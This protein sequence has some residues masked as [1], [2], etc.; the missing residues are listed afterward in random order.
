MNVKN[1][2]VVREIA[3]T[4]YRAE[5]K[6]NVLSVF[7]I[8]MA[9]FFIA[10]MTA[11]GTSYWHTLTERQLRMQGIDYD[12]SLGEPRQD[13]VET[14]RALDSV[15][16]AGIKVLCM[17]AEQYQDLA[18]DGADFYWLDEVCWEK[19]VVPALKA[20]EGQY[21][22]KEEE[23][24]VS[25]ALLNA[26]RITKPSVGM[27]L[28]LTYHTMAKD[29]AGTQV[30]EFTL[31]GWFLD[32][33]G[34]QKGYVSQAFF[35]STGVKQT[36]FELGALTVSLV[37]PLYFSKDLAAMNDAVG[38]AGTQTIEADHGAAERFCRIVAALAAMLCMV[39]ASAYFFI[40]N[41]MYLSISKNI[42]YYGQ[43]K[44][45]GM[46]SVQLKGIV[47][48]QAFFSAVPGIALGL[49][50]AAFVSQTAVPKMLAALGGASEEAPVPA[51]APAFLAAGAF[52]LLVN[53]IS[54]R[55]PAN[56]AGSCSPVEAMRYQPGV[57]K[58]RRRETFSL[59]R[60][61]FWNL[62][63]DKK[64]ASVILLSFVIALSVFLAAN[65]VIYANGAKRILNH[66]S[67]YDIQF[68]NQTMLRGEKQVFTE[69]KLA[70]LSA[71][72][73]VHAVRTV[74]SAAA[75]V[76][77]QE[78]VFGAYYRALYESVYSPGSYEEDIGKYREDEHSEWAEV[79]FG[80]RL[81]A[82]DAAGF[83]K[84][85][86]QLGS[87]LDEKAFAQ[88]EFAVTVEQRFVSGDFGMAGKTVRFR[89]PQ[90]VSPDTE[91]SIRLA[92]VGSAG[93]SPYY[94]SG[95]YTPVI[96]VSEPF[97]KKL[98]GE[99]MAELVEVDYEQ[100]FDEAAEAAVKA[101]FAGEKKVTS[102]SKLER[103]ESMA[104][105]EQKVKVLGCSIAGLIAVLA[106]CN[107]LNMAAAGIQNRA[108]E[109]AALESI[110]MTARQIHTVL[111]LEGAYYGL[112][113]AAVS[114][115]VGIPFSYFV[116]QGLASYSVPFAIP[117]KSSLLFYAAAV[118]LCIAVPVALYR[119]T[120]KESVIERMR[121]GDE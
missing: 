76:P 68:L 48:R 21:P 2:Q 105:D 56:I 5:T 115:V 91:Y 79:F 72:D 17:E 116:F 104:A 51:A 53:R 103:Y 85:N 23:M 47:Y 84:F 87:T 11:T 49:G 108:R 90:G 58:R 114:L 38:I 43:L 75:A 26:M 60:M 88:G 7:A 24:M 27:K 61:A 29:N 41:T 111:R 32:Y 1:R 45:V 92:A 15:R 37:N 3:W 20:Y 81:V 22:Q 35:D 94:F 119:R 71:V 50:C 33:S 100:P 101:V 69:E 4:T 110:G 78:D 54:C 57:A 96:I 117:W 6:R 10:V 40:Y 16:Y 14:V 82:I 31:S 67:D 99:P 64:Q 44:T 36:D 19:Q 28:P 46:T 18:I 70:A 112:A 98:L 106:L 109:F 66:I 80:T 42:R 8:A 52:A 77:Y 39:L 118:A 13:Q 30:R 86:E 97:A 65:A 9:S 59:P 62:S 63:R 120:H 93:A 73:G 12:I 25:T 83:Q 102:R 89:L 74:Y 107:Y 95:G 113:S 55:K 121:R 34:T